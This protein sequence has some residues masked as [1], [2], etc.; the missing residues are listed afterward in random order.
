[1]LK[2]VVSETLYY[3]KKHAIEFAANTQQVDFSEIQ[4]K[5]ISLLPKHGAILDLGC[6]AGR[7]TRKFTQAGFKVE[8]WDGSPELCNIAS[9]YSGIVAKNKLFSELKEKMQYDGIW[10]CASI[11][12]LSRSELG[13]T[14]N[15]IAAALKT[16]GVFYTSFKYGNFEGM[17]N[18]RYFID[19]TEKTF[20]LFMKDYHD[21]KIIDLWRTGDARPDREDEQWLNA[22]MKK[23]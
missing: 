8:A 14:L 23:I 10:A 13:D 7:D 12:H 17:R 5:F 4:D 15:R 1:M 21:F 22:I 16:G 11:L 3:Y 6:G 2:H 20:T 9:R 18:G 19:M